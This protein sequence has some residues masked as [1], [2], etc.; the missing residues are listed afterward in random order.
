MD[1][2]F[3]TGNNAGN[4]LAQCFKSNGS[5]GFKLWFNDSSNN[6]RLTWGTE[7][8][9]VSPASV[10]NREMLVLRHKGGEDVIYAYKSNLASTDILTETLTTTKD[11]V[12]DSTLVLG[13]AKADD[14]AYESHAIGDIHWCKVWY[15]DLGD[16][17][18]RKLAN[19]IHEKIDMEVCGQKRF[20]LTE[21]PNKRSMFSLLAKHLLERPRRYNAT[22]TTAGGWAES[23][24]N[25][26]LNSRLYESIPTQTRL[27]IKQVTVPSS[28]GAGSMNITTS[29]CYITVPAAIEL[30]SSST[31]LEEPYINEMA[32][33]SGKTIS[34][35]VNDSDRRRT[36]A[37]GTSVSY[38]WTRSPSTEY[39]TRICVVD[40]NG[41][42]Y[43]YSYG[44]P[45]N[46]YGVLIEISF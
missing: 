1:Y 23:Q 11:T 31:W 4:V 5:S 28:A 30:N 9:S 17:V 16:S 19:W 39:T 45:T 29:E 33:T 20:Y 22:S 40:N 12:I 26:V 38:Y 2:E 36:Y 37:D 44:S 15:K 24:L 8:S 10:N 34:Y 18:C 21:D 41:Y 25:A 3:F 42:I 7:T 32:I 35:M 6:I 27:L 14:G 13:C 46:T 43:Y